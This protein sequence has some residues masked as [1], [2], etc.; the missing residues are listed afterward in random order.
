MWWNRC[1]IGSLSGVLDFN[2]SVGCSQ[3]FPNFS[4][5]RRPVSKNSALARIR[6]KRSELN[7]IA[8]A[9]TGDDTLA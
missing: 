3:I 9:R 7:A 8:N 4:S 1:V 2:R 6:A 5:A